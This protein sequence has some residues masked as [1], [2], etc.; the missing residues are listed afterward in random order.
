[1]ENITCAAVLAWLLFWT[2][3]DGAISKELLQ[4]LVE[5]AS[6]ENIFY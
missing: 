2:A 3:F 5:R 1:M 6:V 4:R